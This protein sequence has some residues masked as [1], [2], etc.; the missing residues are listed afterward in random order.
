MGIIYAD[1][2]IFTANF[3]RLIR[4]SEIS[5]Y[6]GQSPCVH[7]PNFGKYIPQSK[8]KSFLVNLHVAD[9]TAN[10]AFAQPGHNALHNVSPLLSMC[11]ENY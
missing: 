10:L 7:T 2:K 6:W 11:Q 5:K 1:V 9:N 3:M 8:L 4:K